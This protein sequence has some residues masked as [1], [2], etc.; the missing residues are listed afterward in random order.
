MHCN[1]TNCKGCDFKTPKAVPES[2]TSKQQYIPVYLGGKAGC[3][4]VA[5]CGVDNKTKVEVHKYNESELK[6]ESEYSRIIEIPYDHNFG[7]AVGYWSLI[8]RNT[9]VIFGIDKNTKS[10]TYI[11]VARI[12]GKVHEYVIRKNIAYGRVWFEGGSLIEGSGLRCREW[13]GVSG[14]L[15]LVNCRIPSI[16]GALKLKFAI[17]KNGDVLYEGKSSITVPEGTI[18]QLE[19]MDIN[20]IQEKVLY[21]SKPY[22]KP[23]P[24]RNAFK[25]VSKG[26]IRISILPESGGRGVDIQICCS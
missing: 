17:N 1:C 13:I 19:R 4:R 15:R 24:D 23:I 8:N 5:I 25:M 2:K 6:W 18:I 22:V 21:T 10:L 16:Y 3:E 14:H 9:A 12:R 26:D 11:V 7:V 20:S